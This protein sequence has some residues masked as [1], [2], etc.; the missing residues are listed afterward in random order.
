MCSA[1]VFFHSHSRIFHFKI[2]IWTNAGSPHTH[3]IY[4]T[5]HKIF[6][7]LSIVCIHLRQLNCWPFPILCLYTVLNTRTLYIFK[8]MAMQTNLSFQNI[9]RIL[10]NISSLDKIPLE[11]SRFFLI[12]RFEIETTIIGRSVIIKGIVCT[13]C[14]WNFDRKMSNIVSQLHFTNGSWKKPHDWAPHSFK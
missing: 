5:N 8:W 12:D 9:R 11:I 13:L 10:Y 1:P 6:Q 4:F 3:S 14:M 7:T 2:I